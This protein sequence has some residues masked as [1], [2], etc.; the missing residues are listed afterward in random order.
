MS[1]P[2]PGH[3]GVGAVAL[4]FRAQQLRASPSEELSPQSPQKPAFLLGSCSALGSRRSEADTQSLSTPD[5]VAHPAARESST[6]FT[7]FVQ[8]SIGLPA[9][10]F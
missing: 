4:V 9:P 2:S 8:F 1:L 10:Y 5:L 3:T 7:T 6:A